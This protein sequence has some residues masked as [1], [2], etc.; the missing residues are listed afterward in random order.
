M[1]RFCSLCPLHIAT[2]HDIDCAELQLAFC[3]ECK[4]ELTG[5]ELIIIQLA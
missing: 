1:V 3:G 5:N 2:T 4:L